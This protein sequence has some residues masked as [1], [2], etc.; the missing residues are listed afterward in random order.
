MRSVTHQP[1]E[2]ETGRGAPWPAPSPD[3]T[4]WR[5]DR[6]GAG[7]P[8]Q[9]PADQAIRPE[10]PPE[11]VPAP[12]EPPVPGPPEPPVPPEPPDV[13]PAPRRAL[14]APA[15][16]SRR[17][18]AAEHTGPDVITATPTPGDALLLGDAPPA[19]EDVENEPDPDFEFAPVYRPARDANVGVDLFDGPFPTAYPTPR[20][21]QRGAG[22]RR[23][24]EAPR[25][26]RQLRRPWLTL[27]ALVLLALATSFFAWVAAEPFWLAMGHGHP[28]TVAV[29]RDQGEGLA[30]R[31]RG[32]F[33]AAGEAF[34][35]ARVSITGLPD[36]RCA[37]GTS[38]PA[39]MVS[40][41]GRQAYTAGEDGLGL[42]WGLGFGLVG[43]CALL[44]VWVSGATRFTGRRRVAAVGLAVAAPLLLSV[45]IVAATF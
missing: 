34:E 7:P 39:T 22:P 41:R 23:G 45:G 38:V 13:A 42:R 31:C 20:P 8:G 43:V 5:D 25:R 44:T 11:P 21:R 14:E 28:G 36:A 6:P 3:T 18:R 30:H 29:E 40:P 37:T 16:R 2:D 32:R 27:P 33:V 1:P 35:V 12:T 19:P 26:P 9:E 17:A 4:W 24:P 10:E 15:P